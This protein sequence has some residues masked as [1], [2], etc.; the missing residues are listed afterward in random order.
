[1][2]DTPS[3]VDLRP[4]KQQV[5]KLSDSFVIKNIVLGEPDFLPK[6]EYLAK[7]STWARL[8]SVKKETP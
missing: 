2:S 3:M 6:D 1:M 8:F 7:A 5:L 4:M